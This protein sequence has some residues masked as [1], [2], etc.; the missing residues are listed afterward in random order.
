VKQSLLAIGALLYKL[1][2][3]G[4]NPSANEFAS[5]ESHTRQICNGLYVEFIYRCYEDIEALIRLRFASVS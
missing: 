2:C 3:V 1:K 5:S 4:M